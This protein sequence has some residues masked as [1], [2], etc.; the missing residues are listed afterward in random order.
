MAAECV[1]GGVTRT[2]VSLPMTVPIP[3]PPAQVPKD[4]GVPPIACYGGLL[5]N[6]VTPKIGS[7]VCLHLMLKMRC[8]PCKAAL[9]GRSGPVPRS[10]LTLAQMARVL[11]CRSPKFLWQGKAPA[12]CVHGWG[13]MM[14][15]HSWLIDY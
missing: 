13:M 15:E 11:A 4:K 7:I 12:S 2:C 1:G 5:H 10:A 9:G 3:T 6:L 8:A 14:W